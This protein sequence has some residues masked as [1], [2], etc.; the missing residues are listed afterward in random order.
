MKC[1]GCRGRVKDNNVARGRI[2]KSI[3]FVSRANMV[4]LKN[5]CFQYQ[6]VIN[7]GN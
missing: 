5:A 4:N 3:L 2:R 1:C 7:G 6:Y